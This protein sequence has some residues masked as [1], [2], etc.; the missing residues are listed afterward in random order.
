M[1]YFRYFFAV[2]RIAF[3]REPFTTGVPLA[4][5]MPEGRGKKAYP[6]VTVTIVDTEN[7]TIEVIKA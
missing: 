7:G 4:R 6:A 5:N 1:A 2:C 3:F